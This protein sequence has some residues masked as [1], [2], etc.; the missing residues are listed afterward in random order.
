MENKDSQSVP[1]KISAYIEDD[2]EDIVLK[3]STELIPDEYEHVDNTKALV[4]I[5]CGEHKYDFINTQ[6]FYKCLSEMGYKIPDEHVHFIRTKEYLLK[7]LKDSEVIFN[8]IIF[9]P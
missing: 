4:H 9:N 6:N 7:R 8:I 5:F 1:N 2:M 3:P